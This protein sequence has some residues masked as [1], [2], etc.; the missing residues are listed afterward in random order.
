MK[1][2]PELE[3]LRYYE[4]NAQTAFDRSHSADMEALYA[5]FL[6]FLPPGGR[7]LDAGCGSGRDSCAFLERGY[8]V[9][10]FDGAPAMAALAARHTGLPVHT[11]RFDRVAFSAEFDG[12]WASKSLLHV[13]RRDMPDALARL[14]RALRPGGILYASFMAGAGERMRGSVFFNDYTEDTLQAELNAHESLTVLQLWRTAD[15]PPS[16]PDVVWLN[17]LAHKRRTGASALEEPAHR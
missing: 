8:Q 16:R 6:A 11:L 17:V 5:P 12:V 7:V 4:A 1:S 14:V 15:P 9:I 2:T 10:A 13:T 3:V